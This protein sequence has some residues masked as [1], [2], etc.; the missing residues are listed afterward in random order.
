LDIWGLVQLFFNIVFGLSIF[1]LWLRLQR[2]PKDD[3]R[4]SHGLQLLQSKIAVL[5]DLSDRT[6]IQFKQM[7]T[8]LENKTKE[9]QAKIQMAESQIHRV[10]QSMERSLEVAQIFQDKIPHQE[11]IQRQS[12]QRY[13]KAAQLAHQGL[14]VEEIM[15]QCDLPRGEIEFIA[16]INR[17]QLMFA[18]EA[19][20]TWARAN[21]DQTA[22]KDLGTQFRHAP[23]PQNFVEIPEEAAISNSSFELVSFAQEPVIEKKSTTPVAPSIEEAIAISLERMKT[24]P[25]LNQPISHSRPNPPPPPTIG[26]PSMTSQRMSRSHNVLEEGSPGYSEVRRFEFPRIDQES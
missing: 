1:V 10:D 21:D 20:P 2:P 23:V 25:A 12:T 9:I 16:K 14:S 17:D 6:E 7:T 4:L 13:V 26:A 18:P 15:K 11:I 19:L 24:S 5:E 3:P 22:L 8:M